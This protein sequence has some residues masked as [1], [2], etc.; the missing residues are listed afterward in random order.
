MNKTNPG[1]LAYVPSTRLEVA[2]EWKA[3]T[4]ARYLMIANKTNDNCKRI[5]NRWELKS[6]RDHLLEGITLLR[7]ASTACSNEN[8]FV[9]LVDV[10]RTGVQTKAIHHP[11]ATRP[12]H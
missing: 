7:S 2:K 6:Q 9:L 8:E 5:V 12:C 1:L 3:D 11:E 10:L 4:C